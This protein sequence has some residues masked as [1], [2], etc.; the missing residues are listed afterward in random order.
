MDGKHQSD[1]D[2]IMAIYDALPDEVKK[3]IQQRD[4]RTSLHELVIIKN[5]CKMV[6]G[7]KMV[8]ELHKYDQFNKILQGII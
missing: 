2:K 5:K 4:V 8:D 6:S 1:K 3:Y 7:Q